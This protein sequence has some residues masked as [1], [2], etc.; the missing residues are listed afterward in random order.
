MAYMGGG[1]YYD[2]AN[3]GS[4]PV[5]PGASIAF[6][7]GRVYRTDIDD[8]RVVFDDLPGES[9]FGV[10]SIGDVSADR[11]DFSYR[12]YSAEGVPI[13]TGDRTVVTGS[14]ADI[15]GDGLSD[16]S[17]YVAD[18]ARPGM[19]RCVWLNFE[20]LK[21]TLHTTMFSLIPD[22]YPG[23]SYPSGFMGMNTNGR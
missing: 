21:E 19:E 9:K 1:V 13:G 6:R 3:P 4:N 18:S 23:G 17:W 15:D 22:Q 12:L 16:L 7:L 2:A 20:S 10:L 11:L 5:V 8:G 14:E